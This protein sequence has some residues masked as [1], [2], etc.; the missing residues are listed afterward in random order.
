M[1][2]STFLS[3]IFLILF[4]SSGCARPHYVETEPQQRS[5][6]PVRTDASTYVMLVSV[7]GLRPDAIETFKASTLGRLMKAGSYT[8]SAKT[9]TPS[10]TLPSHTSML[11]GELPGEHG[12]LWNSN[13]MFARGHVSSPTIFGVLRSQG[14]Q[15]AAF[16]SKSKFQHLQRPGTLDYSQAP[17]GWFGHWSADRTVRDVEKYLLQNR[18]NLLFVHLG[19]VDRAGHRSGWMS[20]EYGTAVRVID[21][22]IDRLVATAERTYGA[23]NFTVI[24]TADHGGHDKDH[25]SE[26]PRD[27]NIP[28]I[29]W[30]RGVQ[31]GP[32]SAPIQTMDT[33]STVLWLFGV[34]EP[35]DWA[36]KPVTTAFEAPTN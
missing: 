33:A 5:A 8:L 18:P 20:E 32:I 30:G 13:Q 31:P 7:D 34:G 29:V 25:G 23:G 3:S 4:L 35:S 12:V 21:G 26:D 15:T 22:A 28:W 19:E 6:Q 11:T 2:R 36:G 16:F 17:G 14:F 1:I 24:I 9:I 27:V 10:K